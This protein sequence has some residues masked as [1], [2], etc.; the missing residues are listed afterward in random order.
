MSAELLRKCA[1]K[2]RENAEAAAESDAHP[3]WTAIP[4]FDPSNDGWIVAHDPSH[5]DYDTTVAR[6]EYDHEGG[7]SRH[8][9]SWHPNI[10]LAV[11]DWLDNED[12]MCGGYPNILAVAVARAYLGEA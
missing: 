12:L 11:A 8:I 9:A 1:A 3:K 10:A 2:I 6:A 4:T 7:L 5:A